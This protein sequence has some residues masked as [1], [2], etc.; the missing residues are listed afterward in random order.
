MLLLEVVQLA[1]VVVLSLGTVAAASLPFIFA[2]LQ[3]IAVG[4][5][6]QPEG[7]QKVILVHLVDGAW[8]CGMVFLDQ[9]RQVF[10]G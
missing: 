4:D 8:Q 10:I 2:P 9:R 1:V 7:L 6:V 5:R 3:Q